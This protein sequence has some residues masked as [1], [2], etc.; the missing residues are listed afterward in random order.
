MQSGAVLTASSSQAKNWYGLYKASRNVVT[1]N[2]HAVS[3]MIWGCQY[4][5]IM[6]WL[7]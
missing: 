4:D 7:N 5:E 6:N 2:S 1:G 3:T